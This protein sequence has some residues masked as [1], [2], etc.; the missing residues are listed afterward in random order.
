MSV[1]VTLCHMISGYREIYY[2][3]YDPSGDRAGVTF[4]GDQG[5]VG[6][7]H[8]DCP[9]RRAGNAQTLFFQTSSSPYWILGPGGR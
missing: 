7:R 3:A 4:G 1:N 8:S 6:H 9:D 2:Q 5:I